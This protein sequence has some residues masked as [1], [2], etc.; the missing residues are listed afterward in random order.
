MDERPNPPTDPEWVQSL[1]PGWQKER[2][3]NFHHGA[4]EGLR[5]GE[6][7]LVCDIW[8]EISR[9]LAAELEAEGWPELTLRANRGAAGSDRLRRDG[10]TA[11]P[12]R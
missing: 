6:P 7:D 1:K 4:M 8:T 3:E 10:A 9:N 12:R 2:Q 11:P 5:P